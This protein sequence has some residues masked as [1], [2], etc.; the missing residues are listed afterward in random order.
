MAEQRLTHEEVIRVAQAMSKRQMLDDDVR[1]L[2]LGSGVL[3]VAIPDVIRAFPNDGTQSFAEFM[4]K[5][6]PERPHWF[7]PPEIGHNIDPALIEAALGSRPTLAARANL[8]AAC[9]A[10][11][12]VGLYGALVAA[13]GAS[14]RTL[15][16]GKRP[17]TT[18]NGATD[19]PPARKKP[20]KS[21][22][23]SKEGWNISGQ[24]KLVLALGEKKAAQIAEAAGCHIGSTKFNPDY[25]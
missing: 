13:W 10:A 16:P 7:K 24:G 3:P 25:N 1:E 14:E 2:A 22:P 15:A 6:K 17:T 18:T 8:R 19:E 21:N 5:A 12:G 4:A 20:D 9:I 23:F 11:D